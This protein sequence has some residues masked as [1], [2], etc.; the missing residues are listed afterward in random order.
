MTE[1]WEV[2]D[3]YGRPSVRYSYEPVERVLRA[4]LATVD[5]SGWVKDLGS[6]GRQGDALGVNRAQVRRWRLN[7]LTEASAEKVAERL[8]FL[9]CELWPSMLDRAIAEVENEC[10]ASDCTER[11]TLPARGGFR[12]YCSPTCRRREKMRRYRARPHGAEQ[13]RAYVARY[14]AEVREAAQRRKKAA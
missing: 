5:A 7:G 8:G 2:S 12:G 14:R 3:R 10:G 1:S 4:R 9:G 13:N 6:S 11:F